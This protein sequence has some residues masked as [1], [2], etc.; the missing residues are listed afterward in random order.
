M[1]RVSI[2]FTLLGERSNVPLQSDDIVEQLRVVKVALLRVHQEV[3]PMALYLERDGGGAVGATRVQAVD[4]AEWD[5]ELARAA[6]VRV[7]DQLHHVPATLQ[8]QLVDA[9]LRVDPGEEQHNV[10]CKSYV[11]YVLA[12]ML[13]CQFSPEF[14]FFLWIFLIFPPRNLFLIF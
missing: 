7:R 4:G 5:V 14:C 2:T 1:I 13:L 10:A 6:H 12:G 11:G 9:A 3:E 8:D